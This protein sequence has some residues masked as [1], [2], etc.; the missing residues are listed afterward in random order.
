MITKERAARITEN[1]KNRGRTLD[2]G[3]KIA[4]GYLA[5]C[6]DFAKRT[7]TSFDDRV[8]NNKAINFYEV[9]L[10]ELRDLKAGKIY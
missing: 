9:V 1:L 4:E 3:I 10:D 7:D 5:E 6:R 8:A 2:E